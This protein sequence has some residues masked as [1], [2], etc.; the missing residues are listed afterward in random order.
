MAKQSITVRVEPELV[1]WFRDEAQFPL[2]QAVNEGLRQLQL[3]LLVE[4]LNARVDRELREGEAL[5]SQDELDAWSND[6]GDD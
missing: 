4:Q 2:G 1:R 3:K 6:G 5:V